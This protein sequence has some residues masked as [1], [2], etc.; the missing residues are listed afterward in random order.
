[1]KLLGFHEAIGDVI[2]LSVSTPQHLRKLINK[3]KH[4]EITKPECNE[5]DINFLYFMALQKIAFL[6]FAF[7]VFQWQ[8]DVFSKNMKMEEYNEYWWKLR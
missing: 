6:P 4:R 5:V 2:G 3:D 1:M 7:I 8:S